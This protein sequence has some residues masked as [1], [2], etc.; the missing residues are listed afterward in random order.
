MSDRTPNRAV[1]GGEEVGEGGRR[2]RG[3]GDFPTE[4][5]GGA[6]ESTASPN[7]AKFFQRVMRVT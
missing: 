1:W 7:E 5:G 6:D 4:V 3:E 2:G